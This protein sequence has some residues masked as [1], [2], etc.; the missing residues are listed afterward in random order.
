MVPCACIRAADTRSCG[1]RGVPCWRSALADRWSDD[2]AT[3]DCQRG[4]CGVPTGGGEPFQAARI[5]TC[6]QASGRQ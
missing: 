5:D 6:L 1:S 2:A 3:W 4:E